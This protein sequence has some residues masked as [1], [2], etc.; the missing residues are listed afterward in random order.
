MRMAESFTQV[1][2]V[3][4][5]RDVKRVTRAKNYIARSMCKA[6][7]TVIEGDALEVDVKAISYF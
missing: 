3:T 7:I 1:Q 2:I 6:D 5:E 4:I